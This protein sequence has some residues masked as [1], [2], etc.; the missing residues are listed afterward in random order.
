[1]KSFSKISSVIIVAAMGAVF[2]STAWADD[3]AAKP[4]RYQS[5]TKSQ[6]VEKVAVT[7][8]VTCPACKNEYAPAV[9]QDTKLKTRTVLVATHG[10][11]QCKTA[12]VGAGAQ[13]ATGKNTIKHTC[14][15]LV[16]AVET[17]CA[18][19]K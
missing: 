12:V 5:P 13:K 2:T 18:T 10:C 11:T 14:G 3:V 8:A 15:A 9:T 19:M 17:C 1:M 4:L 6:F 7:P 16:A